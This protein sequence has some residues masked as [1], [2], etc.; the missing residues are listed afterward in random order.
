VIATAH[1]HGGYAQVSTVSCPAAGDCAAGGYYL[2][3]PGS[4][5][6][7]QAFLATLEGY[8]WQPVEEVPRTQVLNKA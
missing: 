4:S 1:N 7:Y 8:A 3:A 5:Q 6:K 2:T